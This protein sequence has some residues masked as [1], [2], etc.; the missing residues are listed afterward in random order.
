MLK[1]N[2]NSR[3][4]SLFSFL[5]PPSKR[6]RRLLRREEPEAPLALDALP[7]ELV[8]GAKARGV[9]RQSGLVADVFLFFI[10][11]FDV[12]MKR[13]KRSRSRSRGR[14]EKKERKREALR[15]SFFV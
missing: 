15:L 7:A 4:L 10:S 6:R 8:V 5:L 12:E 1:Q 2:Q 14:S 9:G 13:R 3:F 11:D